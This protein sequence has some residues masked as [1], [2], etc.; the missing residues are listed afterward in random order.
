MCSIYWISR[1]FLQG[2]YIA[3]KFCLHLPD[4]IKGKNKFQMGGRMPLTNHRRCEM[5][6]QLSWVK[7]AL[8]GFIAA[9]V[10][11][12]VFLSAVPVQAAPLGQGTTPPT[13]E[14]ARL[15]ELVRLERAYQREQKSLDAQTGRLAKTEEMVGKVE[16]KIAEL[17]AKGLDTSALEEALAA[18]QESAVKA[19]ADHDYAAEILVAHAGFDANGKVTDVQGAISTVKEAHQSLQDARQELRP[20]LRDLLQA[21]REF[22][23]DNWPKP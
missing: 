17:K 19:Q 16:A 8:T 9:V 20:A 4:M 15:K 1:S 18:Y 2:F 11:G 6:S 23:R 3:V 21:L 7:K 14:D 22:R 13:G 10:V 5:I 12:G